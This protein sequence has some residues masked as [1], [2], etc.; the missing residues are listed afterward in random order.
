MIFNKD[1]SEKEFAFALSERYNLDL[2]C[3]TRGSNGAALLSNGNFL[4][5]AGTKVTVADTVGAGDSFSAGL[6]TAFLNEIEPEKAIKLAN[7]IGGFVASSNGAIPEY[8]KAIKGKIRKY[9][10]EYK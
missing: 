10:Y 4:E 5:T 2:V 7:E 8:S 6:L 9:F 1:M 3:I